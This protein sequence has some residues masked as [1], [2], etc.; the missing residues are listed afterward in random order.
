MLHVTETVSVGATRPS[1]ADPV[2]LIIGELDPIVMQTKEAMARVWLDRSVSKSHLHV[3]MLLEQFGPLAMGRL[4]GM[5]EVALPNMTGMVD[6]ME[7]HG[8]VIR[9]RDPNDRR[10]VLVSATAKGA[11][12]AAEIPR[13]RREYLRRVICALTD[14]ERANCYAAFR[15]IR[16]AAAELGSQPAQEGGI[17]PTPT[18]PAALNP[19]SPSR[20]GL[21]PP[22]VSALA[23]E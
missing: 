16:L 4:A 18:P 6:R 21:V 23:E 3:L 10:V 7:E 19:G 20:T 14:Q 11:E 17:S 15:A 8:L 13:I 22:P 2:E 12:L 5:A 1:D 9:S